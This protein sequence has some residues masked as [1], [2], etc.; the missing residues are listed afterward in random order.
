MI[1]IL[2]LL[3]KPTKYM[4]DLVPYEFDNVLIRYFGENKAR[5]YTAGLELRLTLAN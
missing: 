1:E 5:G 2:R 4:W 3:Q